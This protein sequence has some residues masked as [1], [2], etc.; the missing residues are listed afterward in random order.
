MCWQKHDLVAGQQSSLLDATGDDHADTLDLANAANR[1]TKQRLGESRWH[2][3][4]SVESID[5]SVDMNLAPRSGL[6]I[7]KA[8]SY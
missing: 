7:Y 4:D 6:C 5:K 8:E 1:H 3:D 2:L